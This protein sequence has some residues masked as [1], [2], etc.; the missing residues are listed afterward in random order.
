MEE[1]W[2]FHNIRVGRVLKLRN[3]NLICYRSKI[4]FVISTCPQR[5]G[6]SSYDVNNIQ[7]FSKFSA[8]DYICFQWMSNCYETFSTE[9]PTIISKFEFYSTWIPIIKMSHRKGLA[10]DAYV[11]SGQINTFIMKEW[12]QNT[13][14][15]K[16]KLLPL[17]LRKKQ[18]P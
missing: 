9:N 8:Y 6:F 4:L 11:Y 14:P 12:L 13:V 2:N 16:Q 18:T 15:F 3:F 1:F 5:V 7:S 17:V 10:I